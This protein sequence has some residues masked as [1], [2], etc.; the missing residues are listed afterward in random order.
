M[1]LQRAAVVSVRAGKLA[2][3][4]VAEVVFAAHASVVRRLLA[5]FVWC[6]VWLRGFAAHRDFVKREVRGGL[7]SSGEERAVLFVMSLKGGGCS[8]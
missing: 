2:G 5:V 1:C 6:W 4:V 7:G 8:K 3:T